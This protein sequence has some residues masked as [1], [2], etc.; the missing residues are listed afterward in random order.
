MDLRYRS[1]RKRWQ[2][3]QQEAER[4]SKIIVDPRVTPTG[5]M[6]KLEHQLQVLLKPIATDIDAMWDT[7]DMELSVA[8]QDAIDWME[9]INSFHEEVNEKTHKQFWA[10][11]YE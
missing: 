9:R 11:L 10:L 5:E 6:H 2:A 3:I 4:I 1:A 7:V 8:S